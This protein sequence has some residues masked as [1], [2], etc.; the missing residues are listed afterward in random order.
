[1]SLITNLDI[2]PLPVPIPNVGGL[3]GAN[4][5]VLDPDFGTKICRLTDAF[6]GD[7]TGKSMQTAND[8]NHMLWNTDD[9]MFVAQNTTGYS[10]IF[11]FDPVGLQG[12]SLPGIYTGALEFSSV[13]NN[14]L[15]NLAPISSPTVVN[16]LTFAL[17][18]GTWTLQS[19]K[20][21]CDF[22]NILPNNFN[23]QWHGSFYHSLD[24][25]TFCAS[26]SQ[27]EQETAYLL[28]VYKVGYGYRMLNTQTGEIIGDWGAVG[29]WIQN[30][31]Y[32]NFY[33]HDAYQTPNSNYAVL[34][35]SNNSGSGYVIWNLSTLNLLYSDGLGNQAR[36]YLGYYCETPGGGE[37]QYILYANAASS[38]LL[39][40]TNLPANQIPRQDYEG[41]Q[42]GGFGS[43]SQT[44]ASIFWVT[45]SS[46]V[47]S[48]TSCWMNEVR[49][50]ATNA[51]SLGGP[52]YRA[53]HTFNSGQ[54]TESIVAAAVGVPSQ[55]GNFVAFTSD[56]FGTLGSNTG[57]ADGVVGKNAR[58]DI[59]IVSTET[60]IA[61][62]DFIVT[63]FPA[64]Q[65]VLQGNSV[66]YTISVT[67]ESGFD[68]SVNL[69]VI[70]L[71]TD[72]T[73][74][75]S[76]PSLINGNSLLQII[77]GE[78]VVPGTYTFS[79]IGTSGFI[80]HSVT[81]TL[82]V[83]DTAPSNDFSLST[84]VSNL[85]IVRG[86]SAV[87]TITVSPGASFVSNVTLSIN[88]IPDVSTSS[89]TPTFIN[90][91]D[92]QLEIDTDTS[93]PAGFYPLMVTGTSGAITHNISL[94]LTIIPTPNSNDY[95][96]TA[97]PV[98][99]I[100]PQGSS[101][102]Y[103]LNII[104]SVDYAGTITISLDGNPDGTEATISPSQLTFGGRHSIGFLP[105]GP[106]IILVPLAPE[107]A[108]SG[109]TM[110]VNQ[111]LLEI[112]IDEDAP[113]GSY[114]LTITGD[115]GQSV[116]T[117]NIVLQIISNITGSFSL[118][119]V[120]DAP[121]VVAGQSVSCTVSII[122]VGGFSDVVN[123]SVQGFPAGVGFVLNPLSLTSGNVDL[124]INVGDYVPVGT[125]PFTVVGTSGS[126]IYTITTTLFVVSNSLANANQPFLILW[127]DEFDNPV[128]QA[129]FPIGFPGTSSLP[130][131]LQ[132]QSNSATLGTFETLMGVK[133][134]LTGDAEDINTVQN[135]WPFLGGSVNPQLSGG[136]DISFD[137]G[138]TFTRF[139]SNHGVEGNPSTWVLLPAEAVGIQGVAGVIGA[140]DLAHFIIRYVIPP[141]ATQF[142]KLNVLIS[143]GFD[144][145]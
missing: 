41:D 128:T 54:S 124:Q 21:I 40:P 57:T 13:S 142:G 64:T 46:K 125:Y 75:L 129:I 37:W 80:S 53:C 95:G 76:P 31:P 93:T 29:S 81:V 27:N 130:Q 141:E 87:Y 18:S 17:V 7:A 99:Q 9:T 51:T 118:T 8:A 119:V 104:E 113:I 52:V 48:F 98:L 11:Q 121:T 45:S 65:T 71:P 43:I 88:D 78:E 24:D 2:I 94:T 84:T 47:T 131:Q 44:D 26:F 33:I 108:P 105:G 12:T 103:V 92:I 55:T 19:T 74:S 60:N 66:N 6:S 73:A 25:T 136:V 96:L 14:I 5:I 107:N 62:G 90:S 22:A 126:D 39:S 145:I 3:S 28:C 35:I 139:D 111:A 16:Q 69:S 144:I 34:S 117:L 115:D 1:M 72:V 83:V 42:H 38:L 70:G 100:V 120:P 116:H 101:A 106:I 15:Y 68:G 63:N 86:G 67:P 30:T 59:F 36:G 85:S 89:F 102:F 91:G 61:V 122:P 127:K 56:W 32:N 133:F 123:L 134:F 4:T 97:A 132:V 112:D 49:G 82:V 114:P 79:I 58:G 23:S 109:L 138:Q 110:S 50:Y 20:Q 137:F 140:F 10:Y 135:I 77:T 143:M